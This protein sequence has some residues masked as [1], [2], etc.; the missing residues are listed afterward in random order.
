V[1]SAGSRETATTEIP[2]SGSEARSILARDPH[3]RIELDHHDPSSDP[4]T[5]LLPAPATATGDSITSPSPGPSEND[6]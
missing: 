4:L 5:L 3:R 2:R 1:A 6:P